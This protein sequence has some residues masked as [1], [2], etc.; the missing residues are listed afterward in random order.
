MTN[1][2]VTGHYKCF[3]GGDGFPE[4]NGVSRNARARISLEGTVHT[5]PQNTNFPEYS[6]TLEKFYAAEAEEAV[7]ECS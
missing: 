3:T 6:E 5:K 4:R 7:G 1:P 2:Q